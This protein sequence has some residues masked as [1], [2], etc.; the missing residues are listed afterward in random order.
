MAPFDG[1]GSTASKIDS[2]DEEAV[3]FLP[4]SSQ[5]SLML[6][7]SISEGWKAESTL[8]PPSGFQH[9]TL[10]WVS[11][12]LTTRPLLQ[13]LDLSSRNYINIYFISSACICVFH[14]FRGWLRPKLTMVYHVWAPKSIKAIKKDSKKNTN[15]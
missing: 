15:S 11:S 9:S 2:H 13:S 12:V 4:L 1:W 8:E 10:D 14:L 6:L 7:W 3:Y 5:K